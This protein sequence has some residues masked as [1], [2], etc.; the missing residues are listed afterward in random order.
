MDTNF[1]ESV[2]SKVKLKDRD[3]LLIGC[4]YRSPNASD[5][6]FQK[7]KLLFD[8]CRDVN[9]SHKLLIGDLISRTSTGVR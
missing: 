5:D 8:N 3:N 1:K 7:L 4:I 2:W 6:N 9:Y